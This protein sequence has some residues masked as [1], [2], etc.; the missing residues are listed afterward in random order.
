VVGLSLA[1]VAIALPDSVNPSLIATAVYLAVG[2]Q[3][4]RG[5]A[6]FA[7]AAFGAT[8]A[9]GIA[10]ALGVADPLISLV[11]K[12][13][14]TL[15]D[16]LVIAGGAALLA[17]GAVVWI[18]RRSLAG[19]KYPGTSRA[20]RSAALLGVGIAGFELL[21]AFPYF[22]AIAF[23]TA[24]SASSAGKLYLLVLYNVIYALPLFAI[25][26]VRAYMG[27]RAQGVLAR[28][29]DWTLSKW[30]VVVGPLAAAVGVLLMAYGVGRLT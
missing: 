14:R 19:R 13:D 16:A 8:L 4:T 9:G 18:R 2:P 28:A 25:A 11:P 21:T 30:P 15:R 7:V 24:S 26:I 5:T 3:G 10:I 27:P 22:A 29:S 12:P 1:V 17:G 6:V 23:V 20:G